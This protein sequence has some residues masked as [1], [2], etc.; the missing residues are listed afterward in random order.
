M[1]LSTT[2]A[3]LFLV[4]RFSSFKLSTWGS[5]MQKIYKYSYL[6]KSFKSGWI[7]RW[8]LLGFNFFLGILE[9]KTYFVSRCFLPAL[10]DEK[11]MFDG[12]FS[13]QP[14]WHLHY[15]WLI[16]LWALGYITFPEE[17]RKNSSVWG[18]LHFRCIQYNV[19]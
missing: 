8:I 9:K 6:C 16:F 10:P 13:A 2:D 19:V 11:A 14:F 7:V 17:Q 18:Q 12:N 5:F 3:R 1:E 15:F 4:N